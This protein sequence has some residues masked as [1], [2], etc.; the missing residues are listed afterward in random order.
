[1]VSASLSAQEPVKDALNIIEMALFNVLAV[2]ELISENGRTGTTHKVKLSGPTRQ[3]LQFRLLSLRHLS[4]AACDCSAK[5]VALF[6]SPAC[7]ASL[8]SRMAT[9]VTIAIPIPTSPKA[10]SSPAELPHAQSSILF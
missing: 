10:H 4:A 8:D 1:M 6:V 7:F 9:C 2:L 5:Q 3:V